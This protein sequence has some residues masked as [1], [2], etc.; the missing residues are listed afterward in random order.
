M[1]GTAAT[2]LAA[3]GCRAVR[4]ARQHLPSPAVTGVASRCGAPTHQPHASTLTCGVRSSPPCR[5]VVQIPP[6]KLF[7]LAENEGEKNYCFNEVYLNTTV[8]SVVRYWK[9]ST[10][11]YGKGVEP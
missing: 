1:P 3:D 2:E 8:G 10:P 4:P 5:P 11:E 6:V 7:V 9:K